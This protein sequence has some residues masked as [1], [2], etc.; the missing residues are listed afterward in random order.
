MS[1][2]NTITSLLLLMVS[3]NLENEKADKIKTVNCV[4]TI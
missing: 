4:L 2:P 1:F 3:T